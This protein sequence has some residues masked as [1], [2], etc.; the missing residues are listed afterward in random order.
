MHGSW[1]PSFW[2]LFDIICI[3]QELQDINRKQL[4]VIRKLSHEHEQ[5]RDALRADVE[6]Q[7]HEAAARLEAELN[8]LKAQRERQ[9][10][11]LQLPACSS[12]IN[13]AAN[14]PSRF[15]CHRIF[16]LLTVTRRNG[17]DACNRTR[18]NPPYLLRNR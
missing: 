3:A 4:A 18:R 15:I 1:C 12:V 8:E 16:L 5:E 6:A 9:E 2:S 10:V 7:A 14:R 11:R 13:H 17:I